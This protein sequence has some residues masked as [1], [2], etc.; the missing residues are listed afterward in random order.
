M[1]AQLLSTDVQEQVYRRNFVC[2]LADDILWNVGMGIIST[3]TVIPDFVRHLTNS[4]V[5]IGL[6]ATLPTIGGTLP[7]LLVARYIVRYERKKWWFVGPNI[8]ARSM[9]L[10]FASVVLWLGK[11][12]PEIILPV[13]FFCY[14]IQAFSN[15]L[16]GV[17][18]ADLAGSSLDN[19][20]RARALGL[21]T[22]VTG[23]VL[24][25][26][27]PLI[28]V[29][30]GA[31]GP[32]FPDN[33]LVLFVAAGVVLAIGILPGV[34][35][36]E[37]PGSKSVAKLPSLAEF[38]PGLGRALRADVPFRAFIVTRVLVSLFL[39]AA[40]FYVGYATVQLGL[41]SSVAVPILIAA[42]TIGS[43]S[44][45]LAYT[46]LGTHSNVLSI[47]LALGAFILVPVCA[48]LAGVFGPLLL[49]TG[50]LLSGIAVSIWNSSYLNWI[51]GYA[52]PGERPNYVGLSNTLTAVFSF[53]APLIGGTIVQTAGYAPVFAVALLMALGALMVTVRYLGHVRMETSRRVN[54]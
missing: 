4:E 31:S 36:H 8:P 49:Y 23:V 51:V 7:Q 21:R 34:F 43:L 38:L 29:V 45:A 17:P 25:G 9:L 28:G 18:W 16:V 40:P 50:F 12:Q 39:M 32:A 6:I 53:I 2:F 5:L 27:A 54:K 11:G 3:E 41:A 20:W 52:P 33:Y 15:G 42:E 48:L 26:V 14:A 1:E 19:R 13:F 10:L 22:A 37:L 24:L 35:I 30:L 46:W 47:R 44:G